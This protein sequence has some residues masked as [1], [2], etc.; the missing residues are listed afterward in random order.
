MEDHL[1]E[2]GVAA[3]DQ[4]EERGFFT[5]LDMDESEADRT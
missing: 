3:A 2:S 1:H 4:L 5:D